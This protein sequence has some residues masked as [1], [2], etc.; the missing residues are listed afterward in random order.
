MQ[1]HLNYEDT[2]FILNTQ[3]RMIADLLLLDADEELFLSKTA[4]D[5]DFIGTTIDLVLESLLE[6]RQIIDWDAQMHNLADTARRYAALLESMTNGQAAFTVK[7][8]PVMGEML[9]ALASA[10]AERMLKIKEDLNGANP[11][12]NDPR[13][14]S[15][16]ELTFL[17]G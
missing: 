15:V 13:F 6:N 14:V 5:V 17:V 11:T 1:R 10:G 2:I 9:N 8:Y 3:I 7:R 4:E 16:E 12:D